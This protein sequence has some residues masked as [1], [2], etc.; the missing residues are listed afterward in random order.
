VGL[1]NKSGARPCRDALKQTNKQTNC[2]KSGFFDTPPPLDFWWSTP[3]KFDPT[4]IYGK[5]CKTSNAAADTRMEHT[6]PTENTQMGSA[7]RKENDETTT[8]RV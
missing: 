6:K 1:E 4:A 5:K 7:M 2:H 3:F 8:V